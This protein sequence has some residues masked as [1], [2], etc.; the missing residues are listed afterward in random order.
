QL[1]I[2][3]S[4]HAA[5]KENYFLDD[6]AYLATR[7]VIKAAQ[8]KKQGL[9]ISSL[10]EKLEDP[11]EAKEIRFKI[12]AEDFAPYAQGILDRIESAVKDGELAGASLELPNYE[13]V[14]INFD[15]DHGCGWLLIRK[16]LHDPVMPMNVESDISGGVDMIV[17]QLMPILKEFPELSK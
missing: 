12:T 2:E 16:S 7:I 11:L 9:G 3:T 1:A 4:G 13:G 15:K 8:L 14:R 10:L 6:G 17:Q 5:M